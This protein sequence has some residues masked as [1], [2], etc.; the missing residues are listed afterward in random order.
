MKDQTTWSALFELLEGL[1]PPAWHFRDQIPTPLTD[2]VNSDT[3]ERK[4][5]R[6]LGARLGSLNKAEYKD[7][8]GALQL[9]MLTCVI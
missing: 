5:L 8:G 4:G 3:N 6:I 2:E 9:C 1:S 7:I